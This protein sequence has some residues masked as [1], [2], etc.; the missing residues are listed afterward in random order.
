MKRQK[1]KKESIGL[2]DTIEKI[3][4]KTGIKKAVKFAFG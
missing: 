2:G 4:E 3:T 1:I